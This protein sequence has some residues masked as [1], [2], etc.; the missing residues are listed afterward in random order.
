MK[1]KLTIESLRESIITE[2]KRSQLV[3]YSQK[4]AIV[5]ALHSKNL[6]LF[7]Q[8]GRRP[9]LAHQMLAPGKA[10]V[11][12]V[13]DLDD[14][15]KRAVAL[16]LLLMFDY[17]KMNSPQLGSCLLLIL[18]EAH[19]L[20]PKG[21]QLLKKEYVERIAVKIDN[22]VHRGRK[23]R[24]GTILSTQSPADI[25]PLVSSLCNTKVAFR[26]SGADTWVKKNLGKE[27][28]EK[29]KSIKTGRCIINMAGTGLQIPP[30]EIQ[31]SNVTDIQVN[32]HNSH[33][34]TVGY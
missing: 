8:P 11:I 2:V 17:F 6:E 34:L 14:D 1:N 9:L 4:G 23:R 16:Y 18:D 25:N 31:I 27:Y 7:D 28:V 22:I 32:A 15:Q 24:Y 3:H 29:V 5:R 26:L 20:F 19:R 12:D 13:F 10:T 30:I 21:S 33:D